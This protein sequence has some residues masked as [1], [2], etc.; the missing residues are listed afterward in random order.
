MAVG[1]SR[2]QVAE[3]KGSQRL[4]RPVLE[5]SSSARSAPLTRWFLRKENSQGRLDGIDRANQHR[6]H[7]INF[8]ALLGLLPGEPDEP[9]EPE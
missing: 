1:R 7:V 8:A 3:E 2:R 5:D 9:D 4:R 6:I